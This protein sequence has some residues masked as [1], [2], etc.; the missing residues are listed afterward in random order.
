MNYSQLIANDYVQTNQ[1]LVCG[2]G[3]MGQHC[4]IALKK[5]GV[6]VTAIEQV[7]P[8]RWEMLEVPSLLDEL[9]IGDCRQ[10]SILEQ[11]KIKSCRAALIVTSNE[12][13]NIETALVIRQLNPN[14]RLVVRS[15]TDNLNQ[16]L[17]EQLGNFIAYEP[18]ELPTNAFAM[19]ALG[20]EILGFFKVDGHWLR[21]VQNSLEKTGS[22]YLTVGEWETKYKK[23]LAYYPRGINN[24]QNFHDWDGDT[25]IKIGDVLVYVE[26]A[27][28]LLFHPASHAK[29]SSSKRQKQEFLNKHI[30]RYLKSK[31][32][33]FFELSF[34][35]QVRRVAI[36]Y[37]LVIFVLLIIG[38][39]LYVDY[40]PHISKLSAFYATVILLLGGFGDIYGGNIFQSE[41]APWWL[42]LFSLVLNLV[43][44]AFVGVLYALFTEILLSAK[45]QLIKRRP[46]V[47]Q[48]DHVVVIGLARLGKRI[49]S[50]LKD[51]KQTVV[52]VTFNP[53]FDQT[54]IPDIPLIVGDIAEALD[55]ANLATAISIIVVTDDELRNLEVA[56]MAG[57]INP[58]SQL[59]IQTYG[60][61]LSEN[62]QGLL[63]HAQVLRT[64]A[65]A[66]EVF[67][68]AAFGEN[69]IN[70]FRLN[71]RTI[72][73]TEYQIEAGDTLN[74]LLLA[75]IAYGY[76]VVPILHQRPPYSSQLMPSDEI[77]LKIGDR[78]IVL[79]TIEGLQSVE[80]GQRNPKQ[81]RIEI[82]SLTDESVTEEVAQIITYFTGYPLKNVRNVLKK[83]P[84][85]LPCPLYRQQGQRLVKALQD[86]NIKSRI[87]SLSELNE[88]NS[89]YV[90]ML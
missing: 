48:A 61:H 77:M 87:L 41:P 14:T 29:P 30:W 72:L 43:G 18:T 79:A 71:D 8:Q 66:A 81:W 40:Y 73:V 74:G 21:V 90:T 27:E 55:R 12:Q 2:L 6:S 10:T 32:R 13:Y 82:D 60:Q 63:P 64:Y 45:F 7:L 3:A 70:L 58:R 19:A 69:I 23:L 11:A 22:K 75:D 84:R 17:G 57:R 54:Q 85:R 35:Q 33:Q 34:Q 89:N 24:F 28:Q 1:F 49:I 16:L 31:V 15:A 65:V 67:A 56:L 68:G 51:L 47:P 50:L 36:I 25:Q 44:T 39:M 38:T 62:L 88:G 59:V 4:V 52:G 9:I 78:L 42:K 80:V 83:L 76:G 26:T 53:D 46:A 20:T 86:I 5:F 37:S